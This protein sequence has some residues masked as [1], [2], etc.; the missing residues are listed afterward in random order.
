MNEILLSDELLIDINNF[1][2]LAFCKK[3]N[4]QRNKCCFLEH[5]FTQQMNLIS[6]KSEKFER[7][8]ITIEGAFKFDYKSNKY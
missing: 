7:P 1:E 2:K 4:K 5:V 8:K 3:N 6:G